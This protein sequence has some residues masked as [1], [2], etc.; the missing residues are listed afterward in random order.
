M[1][2]TKCI[3]AVIDSI[4]FTL[5]WFY[6]VLKQYWG[7]CISQFRVYLY[8]EQTKNFTRKNFLVITNQDYPR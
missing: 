2:L 4:S 8:F 7:I 1:F 3:F 6:R 5:R